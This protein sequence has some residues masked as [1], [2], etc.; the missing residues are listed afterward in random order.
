MTTEVDLKDIN[1]HEIME[2]T[3]AFIIRVDARYDIFRVEP[4]HEELLLNLYKMY[5]PEFKTFSRDGFKAGFKDFKYTKLNDL[6]M[7]IM[8]DVEELRQLKG[9]EKKQI[10]VDLIVM[11]I[12]RELPAPLPVKLI[13]A[14]IVSIVLPHLID[15]LVE[16][17]KKIN[18]RGL[19]RT[20]KRILTCGSCK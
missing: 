4:E 9:S 11:L 8:A 12:E 5:E 16:L 18:K 20:L 14:K 19:F 13:L 15:Q 2:L 1:M 6:I 7:K 17:T 3:K 10:V